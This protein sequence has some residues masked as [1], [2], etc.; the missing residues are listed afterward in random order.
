M[1]EVARRAGVSKGVVTYH[2]PSKDVLLRQVVLDLYGRVGQRIARRLEQ[3]Q[4]SLSRVLAYLQE[5]LAFVDEHPRHVRA[6]MEVIGNLRSKGG[7][8]FAPQ[9]DDPVLSHLR[10]ILEAGQASGE[11]VRFDAGGLA[12]ILRSAIDAAAARGAVDPAF[13][14][15]K[16][17]AE[18]QR[19]AQ[20]AVERRSEEAPPAHSGAVMAARGPVEKRTKLTGGDDPHG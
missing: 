14:L 4:S 3:E 2:F 7:L 10:E 8:A 15:G 17:T 13:D 16:F 1:A 11:F 19:F 20:R 6:A 9:G 12:V 18:L 5:N